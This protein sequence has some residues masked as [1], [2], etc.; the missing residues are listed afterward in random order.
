M[1]DLAH[2]FAF[3]HRKRKADSD[4]PQ[5]KPVPDSAV[6]APLPDVP[7]DAPRQP[8]LA[9]GSDAWPPSSPQVSSP[10]SAEVVFNTYPPNPTKRP[11]L[12]RIETSL[13]ITRR[14]ASRKSAV[15]AT[16][17][18]PPP[19]A[20]HGSDIEDLGLVSAADPGPS[21]GSLLH[22]RPG[23]KSA[24][25]LSPSVV[26]FFPIDTN[27][28][29][30]PPLQPLV[31]RQ[32]LKELDLDVILRNPQLRHDLLFDPGLQFRP[33]CSRRKR[34]MA[35]RY[36]AAV[37]QEIE[38]GCTCV[39]F[40]S[41][42]KPHSVVCACAQVPT[43]PSHPVVA[44]SSA[45]NVLTLRMP[46]RI[47]D[48]L[49]E[50]LEVLLLVIQPLSS[51]SGMYVNPNTFK[52]QMQEHSA[53]AAYI[54]SIFDPALIEQELKHEVFDPS[55]LFS[56]IG[57]ILKGHCAPMRD[58]AVEAM[59]QAAQACAPGG[60]G[61][62]R[63]A[64]SAVRMCLEILELMKLDIA[65][66]Q[67]QT[68]RP[69]L[70]RTSGQFELKAFKNRKSSHCSLQ[71]TREWLRHAHADLLA[72][73]PMPHPRYP[74][75]S[76]QYDSLPRNQ[77]TYLAVLKGTL[78]LVFD[79][80]PSTPSASSSASSSSSPPPTPVL[81]YTASSSRLQAL[82][83]TAYLD[84][85]RLAL[86]SSEAA[87]ATV[88]YMFL[89]LYRQLVHSESSDSPP[90]SPS[91]LSR[92]DEAD[93]VKLKNE[94][95]D[96]G[97][98]RLGSCF[99][100]RLVPEEGAGANEKELEKGRCTKQDVVLQVAKRAK[101][102]RNPIPSSPLPS[103]PSSPVGEAPDEHMVSLAQR[104]ADSN[105]HPDSR[106]C[107]MLRRRLR[108]VVFNSV[109]A[110]AYPGRESTTG[111]LS[112]IDFSSVHSQSSQ[113]IPFGASTGM[114]P[115]AEEIRSLSEKIARLAL[116]HLNAYLPLYEQDGF[117]A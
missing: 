8:W 68:L 77:Q 3:N 110:I 73:G 96:I 94:I 49:T 23:P 93:L 89:L 104:W 36:W 37:A 60:S 69:F 57:G 30:I 84:S 28:I 71:L 17:S 81:Q 18:R 107:T 102:A 38:S 83:E 4:D 2:D 95:R 25:P 45:L 88:L 7:E 50:F 70:M 43:A 117:L 5:E 51:V 47:R 22:L 100:P 79:P 9:S 76:L 29:H 90:P 52:T 15:K 78:D 97:S 24:D 56:A 98:T 44:Y 26:P 74:S 67:L 20:R 40:D 65:N 55:G 115:L 116:I 63:D 21:S 42:G 82:P 91:D 35:E 11:R 75:G 19:T 112:T 6:V 12:E 10:L 53:Q 64:V 34:S 33:T 54:R 103:Q 111:K 61:S 62:K 92:V 99:S 48:L 108:D 66:H 16:P 109:V 31:N 1:D 114:E 101:E 80:P 13:R 41:H 59:V 39:S 113:Q 106:L 27:S 58:R 32:T 87:D 14:H 86:L 72:R 46:S 105:I 85:A